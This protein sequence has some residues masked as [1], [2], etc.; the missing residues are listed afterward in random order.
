MRF[1]FNL[2]LFSAPHREKKEKERRNERKK[3]P[4]HTQG[5]EQTEH[6]RIRN[7][8]NVCLILVYVIRVK[9]PLYT[10]REYQTGNKK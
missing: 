10:Q 1:H 5:E 8:L 9:Y 2:A 7:I 3:C 4:C 6:K